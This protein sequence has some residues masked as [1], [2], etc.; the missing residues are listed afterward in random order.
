MKYAFRDHEGYPGLD[1]DR[2]AQELA[3]VRKKNGVLTPEAT[4]EE[5]RNKKSPLHPHFEWNDTTA[6]VEYRKQQARRM[7]SSIYLVVEENP[8]WM[9]PA[10]I[11]IKGIGP[12]PSY[13]PVEEVMANPA[14]REETLRKVWETLSRCRRVYAHLEQFAEVWKAIDRTQKKVAK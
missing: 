12:R 10:N 8:D 3:A 11:S 6:A 9:I 1:P 4:V 5:A 13:F 2:L 14:M 7:I